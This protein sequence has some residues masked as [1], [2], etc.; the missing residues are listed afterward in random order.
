M[1]LSVLG[2]R[3]MRRSFFRSF[4][5]AWQGVWYCLKTQPNMRIHL[6]AALIVC[7]AGWQLDIPKVEM[8]VL[9]LTI[10]LVIVTEIMNTAIEKLVDLASPE[11]HPLAKVAKD[12][13]AGAV[14]AAAIVALAIGYYV[15]IPRLA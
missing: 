15:F 1:R 10:G 14:L 13:A 9:L 5:Y 2:V 12:A 7:V 8:A 11:Y 4:Q 6:A 3:V